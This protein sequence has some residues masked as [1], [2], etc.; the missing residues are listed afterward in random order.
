MLHLA[1]FQ[2]QFTHLRRPA[3]VVSTTTPLMQTPAL[4]IPLF[5]KPIVPSHVLKVSSPASS[6]HS[7][8]TPKPIQFKNGYLP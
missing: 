5:V 3:S 8:P 1:M 7:T 2:S 4:Y 6:E